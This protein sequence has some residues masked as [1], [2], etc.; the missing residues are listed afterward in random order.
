M[1]AAHRDFAVFM[2]SILKFFDTDFQL[3]NLPV[4]ALGQWQPAQLL[5]FFESELRNLFLSFSTMTYDALSN[6]S[7]VFAGFSVH[8]V[9]IVR[10][11]T[12]PLPPEANET[13]FSKGQFQRALFKIAEKQTVTGVGSIWAPLRKLRVASIE[14]RVPL[15][16]VKS[17]T[18]VLKNEYVFASA[19]KTPAAVELP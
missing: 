8:G 19:L 5:T 2:T 4:E 7:S 16:A 17:G 11:T 14:K 9:K 3:L 10:S 18:A 13:I 6:A 12:M 1:N 15:D